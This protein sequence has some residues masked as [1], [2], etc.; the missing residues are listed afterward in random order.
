MWESQQ[1]LAQHLCIFSPRS[2]AVQQGACG[3]H[4]KF[5]P[6]SHI[7][8]TPQPWRLREKH[9]HCW[10][11][12]SISSRCGI[13]QSHAG[14]HSFQWINGSMDGPLAK[15]LIREEAGDAGQ[16]VSEILQHLAAMRTWPFFLFCGICYGL[17]LVIGLGLRSAEP[18]CLAAH[19]NGCQPAR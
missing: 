7:L 14:M 11:H 3:N 18:H 12:F 9:T 16:L 13:A 4:T 8:L 17:G 2:H 19:T 1:V 6:G 10:P 5:G 15:A